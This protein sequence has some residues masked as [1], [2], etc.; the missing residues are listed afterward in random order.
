MVSTITE[1]CLLEYL[2]FLQYFRGLWK[3]SLVIGIHISSIIT[4]A[5][6]NAWTENIPLWQ[7]K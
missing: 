4:A 5:L 6:V 1:D 3:P 7:S 2:K